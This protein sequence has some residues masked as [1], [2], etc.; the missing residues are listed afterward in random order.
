MAEPM[1]GEIRM[2][3]GSETP[4]GWA[5]CDGQ[6][7]SISENKALFSILGATYGGDGQTTFAL[8][9][10]RGRTTI[11]PDGNAFRAGKS[12]GEPAHAISVSELPAHAHDALALLGDQAAATGVQTVMSAAPVATLAAQELR[13]VFGLGASTE[14]VAAEAHDN[15]QPYL[16]VTYVIALNGVAPSRK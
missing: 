13:S 3:A 1:I 15:L 8:P 12:G 6:L 11:H 14:A 2:L 5:A 16:V 4:P 10:L 9:N 7:L